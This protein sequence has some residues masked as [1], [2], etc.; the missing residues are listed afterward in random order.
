M[1]LWGGEGPK[2]AANFAVAAFQRGGYAPIS[3]LSMT[4]VLS[5]KVFVA[6]VYRVR[7][8]YT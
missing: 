3:L 4:L 2:C 1:D 5:T 8:P 7:D 6:S